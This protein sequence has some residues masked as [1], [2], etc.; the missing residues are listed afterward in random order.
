M[1]GPWENY[2]SGTAEQGP[3]TKY[4]AAPP[5]APKGDG[6][7]NFNNTTLDEEIP[8]S[9]YGNATMSGLQSV[10][11]AIRGVGQ[12]AMHPVDTVKGMITA[13][14]DVAKGAMQVPAAIH[15]INQSP[16]PLGTYAKAGQEAAA[17]G[18]VQALTA[19][20]TE[21]AIKAVPKIPGAVA[22]AAKP[23][24]RAV[25]PVARAIGDSVN[26]DAIG[27]I[28]PRAAHAVRLAR[29]IGNVAEKAGAEPSVNPGAHLPEAPGTFPGAHLP[30]HP[31]TFS[32]AHLPEAPAPELIKA[33]AIGQG[34]KAAEP[35]PSAGLGKLPVAKP[36]PVIARPNTSPK[37]IQSQLNDSMGVKPLQPGVKL[38]DQ[39]K[40]PTPNA[41]PTDLKPV[42]STAVKAYKY[43]PVK[44]EFTATS[45]NGATYIH[46]DVSPEQ[47]TAFEKATSKGKAWNEIRNSS[48]L[49]GKIVNGQRV[50]H[51][52][53]IRSASPD[54]VTPQRG[55][56]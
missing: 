40:V 44:R 24:A 1:P 49:V 20:A 9:S 55:G 39:G 52:P 15:D 34:S 27:V 11:R 54:D 29:T 53:S 18:G 45:A 4:G 6:E 8:L 22:A 32:G 13:P 31:G 36:E 48:P 12:A 19:A 14:V 23:V 2:Q 33:R 56:S 5:S 28:S 37:A 51:A 38:R 46:G 25:A 16:D 47:A 21:G 17:Q 10:G 7:K 30:E 26:P 35:P 41:T 50:N 43:D 3:W 42:D